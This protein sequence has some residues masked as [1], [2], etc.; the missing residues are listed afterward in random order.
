MERDEYMD[1]RYLGHLILSLALPTILSSRASTVRGTSLLAS[2]R[3]QRAD[4]VT[5][6]YDC[7]NNVDIREI[8]IP[9]IRESLTNNHDAPSQLKS[10]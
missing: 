10:V 8:V 3:E 4:I 5:C 2:P 1:T 7:T 6:Y 9:Y